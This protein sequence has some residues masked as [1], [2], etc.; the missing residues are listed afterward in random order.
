[1][2]S[3]E[4]I[5][6]AMERIADALEKKNA[7]KHSNTIEIHDGERYSIDCGNHGYNGIGPAKIQIT[8]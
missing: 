7:G 1:M 2:S 4:R 6:I 3:E 8:D 5:A